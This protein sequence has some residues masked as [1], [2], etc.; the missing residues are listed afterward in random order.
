[1]RHLS[2]DYL[3]LTIKK[4]GIATAWLLI[5]V[6]FWTG[7]ASPSEK[8]KQACL[9]DRVAKLENRV[10]QLEAILESMSKPH[11]R[12]AADNDLM[13][14]LHQAAYKG[15]PDKVKQLISE[16]AD[17]RAKG[18]DGMTAL[19]MAAMKGHQ[20]TAAALLDGGAVINARDDSGHTAVDLAQLY[21]HEGTA[22]FLREKAL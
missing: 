17:V 21:G 19:H 18:F 2:I 10:A 9:E 8:T 14:P 1:M 11:V 13:G 22:K 5:A 7:C 20:A 16:G 15:Q 4:T 6:F 3:L 12:H